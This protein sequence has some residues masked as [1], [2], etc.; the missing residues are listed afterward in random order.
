MSGQ[1]QHSSDN[2][3]THNR[4]G[5]SVHPQG[6]NMN[7]AIHNTI[8]VPGHFHLTVGSAVTLTFFGIAYWLV[9]KL[10]NKPL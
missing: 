1:L 6:D 8:W 3:I 9:P 10:A 4:E 5:I 7:L 2:A